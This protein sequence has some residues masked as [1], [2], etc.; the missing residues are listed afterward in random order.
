MGKSML[1]I[2]TP[3]KCVD[4]PVHQSTEW[5]SWCGFINSKELDYRDTFITR[6]DWCPLVEVGDET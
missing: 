2:D 4:C 5:A 6:P 1:I 3:E